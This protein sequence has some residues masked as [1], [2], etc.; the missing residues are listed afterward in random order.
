[1][2][3]NGDGRSIGQRI[4]NGEFRR[5]TNAMGPKDAE[6]MADAAAREREIENDF[7]TVVAMPLVRRVKRK[8]PLTSDEEGVLA[9]DVGRDVSNRRFPWH[10]WS[11]GL[12]V[13]FAEAGLSEAQRARRFPDMPER[14]GKHAVIPCDVA[15]RC[16]GDLFWKLVKRGHI[17]AFGRILGRY[18]ELPLFSMYENGARADDLD[19]Y[20]PIFLIFVGALPDDLQPTLSHNR[21]RGGP[22]TGKDWGRESKAITGLKGFYVERSCAKL[23]R[24][25]AL[26]A[27]SRFGFTVRARSRIWEGGAGPNWKVAGKP[28][29]GVVT[30][31]VG[32]VVEALRPALGE[33]L[34]SLAKQAPNALGDEG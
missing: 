12:S 8:A 34:F 7:L 13:P 1:M 5:E 14:F 2:T 22:K 28:G 33:P 3:E 20:Q 30:I 21:G 6:D 10:P 17:A 32:Q 27:L 26:S 16:A 11:N 19:K 9:E 15:N 24:E 31:S 23:R 29:R 18:R 25:D 4:I